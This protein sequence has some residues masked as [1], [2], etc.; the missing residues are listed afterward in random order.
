M[1]ILA[2]VGSQ[3]KRG[4]TARFVQMIG[5]ELG[6]LADRAGQPLTFETLYLGDLDIRPCRGCRTCFDRGEGKC[7]LRD[8]MPAVK[9]KMDAADGLLLASPV[10]V[11]DVSGLTKT[12]IDRLAYLCH[13]PGLGGKCAYPVATVGGSP[14][15]HALRTMNGALLTWGYHLA[16]RTG[17]KMGALTPA[18][19][20]AR[21]RPEAAKVAARLFGA[22]VREDA[23]RPTFVS[24]LAFKIQQLAWQREPADS[25]DVAYWHARGWL[26]SDR[27]FYVA[28][29]AGRFKVA[30]A[31]LAGAVVSRLV[32]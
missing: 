15:S 25:Y 8:D 12:W 9:A 11:D 23:L 5:A 21:F 16:G 32:T 27:T 6:A 1:Y 20:M 19:D 2:I 28:H 24:L 13:R 29:R 4:N 31:R 14:T 17:L 3:R 26:A 18:D 7:P 30:L 10:Y 22:I